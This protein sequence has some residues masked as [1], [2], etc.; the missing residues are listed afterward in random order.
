MLAMALPL[1]AKHIVS[2][3]ILPGTLTMERPLNQ[4]DYRALAQVRCEIRRFLTFSETMARRAGIEPQQHQLL[5]ALK[6]LP[7][8]VRPNIGV[9]SQR[10]QIRHHSGVELVTRS[11][12]RGLVRR[13]PD[14]TDRRS[15]TL[16]LTPRGERILEKLSLAHRAELQ[17]AAPSLVRALESI[18]APK[19]KRSKRKQ[20]Q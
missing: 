17:T 3:Y 16:V 15:V 18:F 13:T 8:G 14:A 9:L 5:L 2:R 4:A 7:D 11:V 20:K 1:F 10:L 12:R 19:D 6:G